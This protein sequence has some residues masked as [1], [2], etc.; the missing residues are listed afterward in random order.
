MMQ[1]FS[2]KTALVTGSISG[3]GKAAAQQPADRGAAQ[4]SR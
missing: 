4:R 3:T 2:G 1:D